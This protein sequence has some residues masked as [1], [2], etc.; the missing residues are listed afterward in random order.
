MRDAPDDEALVRFLLHELDDARA[1]EVAEWVERED[2]ARTR[3]Q[4]YRSLLAALRTR[5]PVDLLPGINEQLA[6]RRSRRRNRAL[7]V[8]VA[9]AA[10]LGLVA[11]V[12]ILRHDDVRAKGTPVRESDWAGLVASRVS[13]EG[14]ASPLAGELLPTDALTFSYT[15]GGPHPFT[16]LLVFGVEASGT[17][18]WYYP[19][20]EDPALDPEASPIVPSSTT[21]DLPEKIT[22]A[23]KPGRFVLHA[24]FARSPMHVSQVERAVAGRPPSQRLELT[25]T[26]E[27]LFFVEVK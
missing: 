6:V 12:G 9:L 18:R 3:L 27:R 1:A 13:P 16:H 20:W 23:L 21:I 2:G 26:T 17:V 5:A 14:V 7:M 8:G 25:D 11:L 4:R 19:A 24:V 10:S 22:H 15:N